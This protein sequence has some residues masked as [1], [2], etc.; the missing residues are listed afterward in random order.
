[1]REFF[2]GWRRK[3][4]CVTLLMVCALMGAWARSYS[5][6][7]SM[8]FTGIRSVGVLTGRPWSIAGKFR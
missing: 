2:K 4:G 1:M 8:Q 7:D 3:M 5:V 6:F